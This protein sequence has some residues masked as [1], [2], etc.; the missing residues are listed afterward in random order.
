METKL[1]LGPLFNGIVAFLI[2]IAVFPVLSDLMLVGPEAT[3]LA[4]RVLKHQFP[5]PL[6][7][8]ISLLGHWHWLSG[9]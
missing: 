9:C 3:P 8:P 7:Q 5:F 2:L 4:D 1:L 6:G